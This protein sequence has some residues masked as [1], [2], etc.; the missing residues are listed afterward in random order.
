MVILHTGGTKRYDDDPGFSE[1]ATGM[2]GGALNYLFRLGVKIMATDSH[3]IDMPIPL[4]TQRFLKGEKESYFPIHRA[5]RYTEWTHAEKLANLS[6]LPRPLGFQVMFFP[7]KVARATGAWIRAVALEDPWLTQESFSLV[8]LSLPIMSRS[9]EPEESRITTTH[10]DQA[11]RIKAKRL[12]LLVADVLHAGAIDEVE[13]YTHA[14]TH[15]DAPF[16]FGPSSNGHG[17]PTV[18]QLPLEMFY[19]NGVLLDFSA[20]K[21]SGETISRADVLGVL[22][23]IG[24]KLKENDI[25]LIRTGAGDCFADDPRFTERGMALE[26]AAFL[27]LLDQ[28]IRV[29]GCDQEWLD[30]PLQP[31]IEALRSGRREKFFPIHYFGR[32]HEFALIHKMDLHGLARPHGFKI[33]AFPIKL[34]GCGAAWTRAVAFVAK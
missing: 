34:E 26:P 9:F 28:G 10:H 25:V 12:G 30:G 11:A 22:E 4:M 5:G 29:V 21:R 18:D 3:T 32:E 31:M 19:G 14:G 16:H 7:I 2:N 15:V 23:R 27:W 20:Q 24:Y 1:S 13:T 33:A 17:T 6:S 8:D